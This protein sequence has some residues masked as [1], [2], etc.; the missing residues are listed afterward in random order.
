MSSI[1]SEK[2][3]HDEVEAYEWVEARVWAM[4]RLAHIVAG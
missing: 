3:F 4:V 2:H 1:L